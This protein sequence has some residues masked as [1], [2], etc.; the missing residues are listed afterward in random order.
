MLSLKRIITFSKRNL[1]E[2]LRDPLGLIFLFLTPISML[3]LFYLLFHSQTS[4]F[5]M[6]ELAPGM[7]SFSH[8]FLCLFTSLLIAQDRSSSFISRLYTTPLKPYE[9]ILGYTFAIIP[10]GLIQTIIMIVIGSIFEPSFLSLSLLLTIPLSIVSIILFTG[11]GIL[12]GSILSDK[13]VGGVAS[14]IIMGQSLLSGMWFPLEEMSHGFNQF[15]R[16]LP[17]RSGSLLF[18]NVC[19]GNFDGFFSILHPL[20]VLLSYSIIIYIASIFVYKKK[21]IEK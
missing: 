12:F 8:V 7:I 3:I 11:F 4:Q 1:K 2:I 10:I 19:K 21:M 14:I 6:S 16:C 5:K 18:I 15:I 13:A 17:F 20:L 9:F